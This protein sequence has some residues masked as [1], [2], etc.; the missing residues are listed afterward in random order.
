MDTKP[1]RTFYDDACHPQRRVEKSWTLFLQGYRSMRR[2][3]IRYQI[4]VSYF[5]S[6]AAC[7]AIFMCGSD[8]LSSDL[9]HYGRTIGPIDRPVHT[10]Y[11]SSDHISNINYPPS[12]SCTLGIRN[13]RSISCF[14]VC[15]MCLVMKLACC[16]ILTITLIVESTSVS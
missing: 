7:C 10:K 1:F 11:R 12:S 4:L 6:A 5:V 3:M 15:T 14:Q 2:I 13:F 16:P 9:Q 8:P